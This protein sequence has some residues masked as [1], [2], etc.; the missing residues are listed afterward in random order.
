MKLWKGNKFLTVRTWWT[1]KG[2]YNEDAGLHGHVHVAC[3]FEVLLFH[4]EQTGHGGTWSSP[5]CGSVSH[6]RPSFS[7]LTMTRASAGKIMIRLHD[8][9]I[10]RNMGMR[11]DTICDNLKCICVAVR[12]NVILQRVIKLQ[13]SITKGSQS[14]EYLSRKDHAIVTSISLRMIRL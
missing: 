14:N 7:L 3:A 2:R 9:S 6:R 4:V 11:S 13:W 1:Q 10:Y 12:N 5:L 8:N